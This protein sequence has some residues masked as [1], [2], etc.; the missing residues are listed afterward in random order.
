MKQ[1]ENVYYFFSNAELNPNKFFKD[2]FVKKTEVPI[3]T[4][5]SNTPR[6]LVI[7][8][9]NTIKNFTFNFKD[10]DYNCSY[11][12]QSLDP[13]KTVFKVTNVLSYSSRKE[14]AAHAFS[15]LIRTIKIN[16][17]SDF[18]MTAIIDSLSTYYSD[19]SR[20]PANEG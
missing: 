12:Y 2:F 15:E 9:E 7:E 10:F 3:K 5:D 13:E 16:K 4:S 17:K 14:Q 20:S 8:I 18:N 11:C 1:F 19:Q 6:L